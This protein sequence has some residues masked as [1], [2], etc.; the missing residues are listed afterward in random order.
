MK[1]GPPVSDIGKGGEL[2]KYDEKYPN[3][4]KPETHLARTLNAG[5][6]WHCKE[7]THWIDTDLMAFICSDECRE[8]KTKER[9]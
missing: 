2:V 8:A 5:R 1:V 9:S 7:P 6:C 4:V 3:D